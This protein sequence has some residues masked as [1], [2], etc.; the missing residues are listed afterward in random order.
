MPTRAPSP[1]T[2]PGCAA[3]VHGARCKAHADV[4]RTRKY[5]R[6]RRERGTAHERGYDAKWRRV[7]RYHLLRNPLCRMCEDEGRTT[8]AQDVDHIVPFTSKSDSRRLD[9][10]N[11]QS[12][13]KACHNRKTFG[14]RTTRSI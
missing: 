5:K 7:R 4:H 8:P 1:C 11:L 3:L 10:S 6:D 9:P 2:H 13:C 14:H 12:L